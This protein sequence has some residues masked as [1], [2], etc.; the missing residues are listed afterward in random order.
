M[1]WKRFP[2]LVLI[3]FRNFFLISCIYDFDSV[4]GYFALFCFFSTKPFTF[5]ITHFDLSSSGYQFTILIDGL[6][7]L[8]PI[9]KTSTNFKQFAIFTH[10]ICSFPCH[11]EQERIIIIAYRLRR[12]NFVDIGKY[13]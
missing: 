4:Y 2:I 5:K 1:E 13:L 6:F 12:R 10:R 9:C 3:V 11:S 8:M 7:M